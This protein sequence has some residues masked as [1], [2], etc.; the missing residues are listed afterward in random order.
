MGRGHLSSKRDSPGAR[1]TNFE[2]VLDLPAKRGISHL[3][4]RNTLRRCDNVPGDVS[5]HPNIRYCFLGAME[6]PFPER[7]RAKRATRRR[8]G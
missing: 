7:H 1:I 2:K 6:L 4:H 5:S 3:H 8:P